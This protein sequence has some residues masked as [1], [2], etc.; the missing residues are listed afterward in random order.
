MQLIMVEEYFKLKRE[1]KKLLEENES[2]KKEIE[3]LKESM[4]SSKK[5]DESHAEQ[6]VKQIEFN[7]KSKI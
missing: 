5:I 6:L 4:I 7:T 1:Y 2:L 3:I